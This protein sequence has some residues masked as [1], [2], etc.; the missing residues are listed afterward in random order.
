MAEAFYGV[1]VVLLILSLYG[2]DARRREKRRRFILKEN[3]PRELSQARLIH[4]E[5][6]ISTLLPRR[7]HG[8][9]DQL[10]RLTSGLH[11]LVDSKTRDKHQVYRKDIVQISIYRV[12]L[13]RNG[14]DMADYAFFR[15]VTPDGVEYIKRNLLTEEEAI[16]EFD[17]TQAL[18]DGKATPS[19]VKHK[20]MCARCPQQINCDD[21]QFLSRQ[22]S[23]ETQ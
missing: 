4:S 22:I 17:R 23:K 3:M 21:W 20:S 8:T 19:N 11:V 12:I 7:M 13:A 6:Y 2:I 14:L 1:I 5:H 18:L 15:V 9:L 10:Y 16:N